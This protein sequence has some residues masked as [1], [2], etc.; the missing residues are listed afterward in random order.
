[1]VK[2]PTNYKEWCAT[3]EGT[4]L[5]KKWKS[6]DTLHYGYY[7]FS[8]L[9]RI[10]NLNIKLDTWYRIVVKAQSTLP[11]KLGNVIKKL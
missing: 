6:F 11:E 1:M 4:K 8:K 3:K 7:Q 5:L 9:N 10:T 2:Q